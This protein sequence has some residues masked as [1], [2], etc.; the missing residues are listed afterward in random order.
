MKKIYT[1]AEQ[2]DI[3]APDATYTV[4][5]D[6]EMISGSAWEFDPL[7]DAVMKLTKPTCRQ[8]IRILPNSLRNTFHDYSNASVILDNELAFNLI[9]KLKVE[10]P[11]M[12]FVKD[13]F[14]FAEKHGVLI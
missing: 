10:K 6:N 3:A 12:W 8:R 2:F 11:N 13:M 7:S 5:V 4:V 14:S 9:E 1:F